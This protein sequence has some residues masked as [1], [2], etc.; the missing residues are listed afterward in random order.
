MEPTRDLVLTT[1]LAVLKNSFEQVGGIVESAQAGR[2]EVSNLYTLLSGNESSAS[3]AAAELERLFDGALL[4]ESESSASINAAVA[5][6][7][8]LIDGAMVDIRYLRDRVG[9]SNTRPIDDGISAL[10]SA[11]K[12]IAKLKNGLDTATKTVKSIQV[13]SVAIDRADLGQTLTVELQE[14]AGAIAEEY[15]RVQRDVDDAQ[16]SRLKGDDTSAERSIKRAWKGYADSLSVHSQGL[17]AEYVDFLAGL[18]LRAAGLDQGICQ[19]AD[20]LV[21]RWEKDL[22]VSWKS[23]TI[24]SYREAESMTPA[25]LIRLGFPEWTIWALPLIAHEFGHVVIASTTPLANLIR[26]N[27]VSARD[28]RHRQEL[29]ADA[30]ATYAMGP[31]Y[32]CAAILLRFNPIG[33]YVSQGNQPAVARRAAVILAILERMDKKDKMGAYEPIINLLRTEWDTALA[34]AHSDVPTETRD[35]D[36]AA[37]AKWLAVEIAWVDTF[38]ISLHDNKRPVYSSDAWTTIDHW[39]GPLRDGNVEGID[40]GP[41]Y[42]LI[43]VLNA[44]WLSRIRDPRATKTIERTAC[45]LWERIQERDK[46]LSDRT[47]SRS[48]AGSDYPGPPPREGNR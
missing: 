28:R 37:F 27:G 33:A 46:N 12:E 32:A 26:S 3:R 10:E 18:A 4:S 9:E 48:T 44:A 45:E 40:P 36:S 35:R 11:K 14:K 29:A 23:L 8:R 34:Q 1:R 41:G 31:A 25:R 16:A 42:G 17:L 47:S 6:L 13:R 24:P 15:S 19:T 22:G 39:T 20:E 30:V 7:E 21:R 5:E 2:Q 38:W 43:D